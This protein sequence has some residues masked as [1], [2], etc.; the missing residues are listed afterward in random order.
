MITRPGIWRDQHWVVLARGTRMPDRCRICNAT[1]DK[2][3]RPRALK[4]KTSEFPRLPGRRAGLLTAVVES[5]MAQRIIVRFGCCPKHKPKVNTK[6]LGAVLLALG[7]AMIP[8]TAMYTKGQEEGM[9]GLVLAVVLLIAGSIAV[10]WPPP[11]EVQQFSD[12]CAWLSGFGEAYLASLP[13]LAEA[14]AESVDEN[15]AALDQMTA[16]ESGD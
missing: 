8:I 10:G 14:H 9:V 3:L 5:A 6:I 1:L 15:A 13:S 7:V 16:D 12:G 2:P 11:V 4:F